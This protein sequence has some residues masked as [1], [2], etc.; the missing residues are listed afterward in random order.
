MIG[1]A[2]MFNLININDSNGYDIITFGDNGKGK[3]KGLGKIA[4]SNDLSISNVLL[5]ESL[6]FNLL[7]VAQLYDLGFKCIFGVDDVEI[8]SVDGSNLVF[9]GCRY[10]NLYLVDFNASD[11]QLSTCLF[12]KSS[13]GW[14]W[15]RRLGHVGMKQLNRLVKLDLVR[16][17][18]DVVFEK[19]KLCSSFQAGKQVGNTHPKK[20]MM[21]TSKAFELLY[22]DLFRPTQYTSIGGNK[23]GFVI[24]DDD[25]RYTWVFFLVD[26]GDMFATLKSFIKGIHNEFETTIKRVRSDNGNEFKNTRIDELCDDFGIRHQFLVKYTPQSNDLVEREYN[27]H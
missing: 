11:A 14:L 1:D 15:H 5:V 27:T 20:N 21:S 8:I 6:N 9:K 7:S 19:D 18:K 23:Y 3:V 24:V 10:K 26:N 4:I 25:T 12:T 16:G 17:L 22:M 2:R 13:M